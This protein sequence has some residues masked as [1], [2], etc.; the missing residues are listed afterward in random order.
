MVPIEAISSGVIEGA[1]RNL[2]NA[3]PSEIRKKLSL[4]N[5]SQTRGGTLAELL[6]AA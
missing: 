2:I 1:C 5:T 3:I 4:W 6:R